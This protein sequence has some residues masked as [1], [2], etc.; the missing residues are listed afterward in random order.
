VFSNSRYDSRI[1]GCK[2][3]GKCLYMMSRCALCVSELKLP[4]YPDA[5]QYARQRAYWRISSILQEKYPG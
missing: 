5:V 3:K 2:E 1:A 4:V